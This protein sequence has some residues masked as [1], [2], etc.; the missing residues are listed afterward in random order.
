MLGMITFVKME[1]IV[2]SRPT[3]RLSDMTAM[4]IK[5]KFKITVR[6]SFSIVC[7]CVCVCVYVRE[8]ERGRG[9]QQGEGLV[10]NMSRLT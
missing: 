7:V 6:L 8:R 4:C 1:R 5:T 3:G 2:S 10:D 9:V